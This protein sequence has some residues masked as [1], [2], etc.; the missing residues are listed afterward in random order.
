MVANGSLMNIAVGLQRSGSDI[1]MYNTKDM[2]HYPS[3]LAEK[4]TVA[5]GH[6]Q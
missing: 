4:V 5:G 1:R 6:V 2:D 3:L